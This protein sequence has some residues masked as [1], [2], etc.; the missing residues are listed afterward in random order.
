M[1]ISFLNMALVPMLEINS[2]SHLLL[3][4]ITAHSSER[5][6]QL[7]FESK[8][9]RAIENIAV[10]LLLTNSHSAGLITL[11]RNLSELTCLSINKYSYFEKILTQE[12]FSSAKKCLH[13]KP[14]TLFFLIEKQSEY[15]RSQYIDKQECLTVY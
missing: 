4:G 10:A 7:K 8:K 5:H 12:I 13:T 14:K 15:N 2:M 3:Q 9:M 1:L 11:G 6:L